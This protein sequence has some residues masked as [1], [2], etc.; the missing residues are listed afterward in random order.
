MGVTIPTVEKF[1]LCLRLKTGTI[2]LGVLNLIGCLIGVGVTIFM[3]VGYALVSDFLGT[4]LNRNQHRN[5]D[6]AALVLGASNIVVY[7]T[8]SIILIIC[9][10]YIIISSL[11]IHG[12]RTSR[13]S[14]LTPWLILTA[15][16]MVLQVLKLIALF[17][18]LEFGQGGGA[19][20][21]LIIEGYL[22]VCVWSFRKQLLNGIPVPTVE[23][24]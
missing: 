23:K 22:F 15:I 17:V 19:I 14:L 9:I 7:V 5:N 2:V 11:L 21:G 16:S 10:F 18:N 6:S 3:I 1:C 24:A 13:P 12:A 20:L 8:T 4:E